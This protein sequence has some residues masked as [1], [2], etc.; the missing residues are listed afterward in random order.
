MSNVM[1]FFFSSRRR[2]TRW[3]GDWSSDVCS[4][5]LLDTRRAEETAGSIGGDKIRTERV[6]VT[7]VEE[8]AGLI[9]RGGYDLVVNVAPP[10][11]IPHVMKASLDA[12]RDYLD[13]S[14]VS[15]Y[16][17]DG[18]PF[19]Q[20]QFADRWKASGRTALINGG[21]APGLTNI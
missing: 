3:T 7:N 17:T 20:L 18:L 12:D 19:E 1:G 21:S 13:L 14:S 11:F 15:L 6:D 10:Q 9:R 4:S 5:D 16:E 8:T 2:H